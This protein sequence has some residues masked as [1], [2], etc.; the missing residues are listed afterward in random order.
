MEFREGTLEH[1]EALPWRFF[2]MLINKGG[3]MMNQA[4]DSNLFDLVNY[5]TIKCPVIAKPNITQ[6]VSQLIPDN[7]EKE[8]HSQLSIQEPYYPV[9]ALEPCL[10]FLAVFIPLFLSVVINGNTIIYILV[11]LIGKLVGAP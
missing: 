8:I 7:Q 4:L 9:F 10:V 6:T 11:E 2:F 1:K 3:D 5:P